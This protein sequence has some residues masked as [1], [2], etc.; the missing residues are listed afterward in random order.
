M[1]SLV[2]GVSSEVLVVTVVVFVCLLTVVVVPG[3]GAR[4]R[5]DVVVVKVLVVLDYFR[6]LFNPAGMLQVEEAKPS[7]FNR[8]FK[9][10]EPLLR[11]GVLGLILRRFK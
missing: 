3:E 1:W 11:S 8:L 5:L 7:F 2:V 10:D 4:V 6:F 9:A